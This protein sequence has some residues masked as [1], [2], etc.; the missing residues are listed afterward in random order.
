MEMGNLQAARNP[1]DV[2]GR[3]GVGGENFSEGK[4]RNV[5][6]AAPLFH[7]RAPDTEYSLVDILF[8]QFLHQKSELSLP[9]PPAFGSGNMEDF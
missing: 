6:L 7:F 1:F 4:K 8:G 3:H 5:V 9:A 2:H